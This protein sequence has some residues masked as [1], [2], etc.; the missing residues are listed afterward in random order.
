MIRESNEGYAKLILLLSSIKDIHDPTAI[1]KKVLSLVGNFDLDPDRVLDII[2]E[3]R[4]LNNEGKHYLTL[5][6]NFRKES[7]VITV[8]NR[9]K[10]KKT[11]G[12]N[13]EPLS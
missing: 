5:L 4:M 13:S 1:W 3:A 6:K 8:G 11:K 9:L 7:I 12:D 10:T 2:V